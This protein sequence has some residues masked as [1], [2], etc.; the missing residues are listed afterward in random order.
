VAWNVVVYV[1]LIATWLATLLRRGPARPGPLVRG[2]QAVLRFGRHLPK[3]SSS[4]SKTGLGS[5]AAL[6]QFAKL[7]VARGA[8]LSTLRAETVLH[9]GAAAL[10]LGLIA[11]LYAR[12]VVLDYRVA[13]ESTFLSPGAAHRLLSFLLAPASKLSGIGLPDAA[14][15]AALQAA[16]GDT[17]PGAPAGPWI[18][19]IALTLLLFVVL[20]RTA[21]A[22]GCGARAAAR[23]RRF[24]LALDTAYF[25]RLL[26]L[27]RGAAA[28]VEVWPYAWTPSPQA[29]LGL[30][31][32]VART[33]G[34]RVALQIAP[35]SAFGTEDDALA[36]PEA[37]T[38]AIALFEL[39][40]TPEAESHGRFVRQLIH[41]APAS[42][43]V[44]VMVDETAF[45]QRFQGAPE[46]LGQRRE[47]WQLWS[48]GLST[49]M[50]FIDLEAPA[51]AEAE[52]GLQ[53]A[54]AAPARAG[55]E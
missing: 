24:T 52:A 18:H 10:A 55:R 13:W 43:A 22:L 41:A 9:A 15:F 23:A 16:H 8:R 21:L 38:H 1:A 51:L 26:R 37:V 27:Q 14:G 19:L 40:A 35:T 53:A 36:V 39:S 33:F 5:A 25:Q 2:M 4:A 12:G 17:A 7:W 45:R 42:A 48:D 46:R 28:H 49:R 34:A 47:A 44:V 20:P 30:Q 50:V 11:G 31:A 54:Y 32:L 29:T 6:R 3:G